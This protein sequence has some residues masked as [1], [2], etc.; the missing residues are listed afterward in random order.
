[1]TH[2]NG[3]LRYGQ[4]TNTVLTNVFFKRVK[5]KIIYLRTVKVM[6]SFHLR[7]RP[8]IVR[9]WV[10]VFGPTLHNVTDRYHTVTI[11]FGTVPHRSSLSLTALNSVKRFE[12]GF[13]N[14]VQK[15][16]QTWNWFQ[17]VLVNS[18]IFGEK[19]ANG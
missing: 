15:C 14:K 3:A 17:R 2:W 8:V 13:K 1:M 7:Y 5:I 16:I 10:T 6:I 19:S 18:D 9:F 4:V 12:F 11:P